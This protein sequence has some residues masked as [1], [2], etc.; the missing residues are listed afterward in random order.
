MRTFWEIF[1]LFLGI[2]LNPPPCENS[3]VQNLL[4]FTN[5]S[6][7]AGKISSGAVALKCQGVDLKNLN[8]WSLTTVKIYP[9]LHGNAKLNSYIFSRGRVVSCHSYGSQ[10]TKTKEHVKTFEDCT[11][12]RFAVPS[13]SFSFLWDDM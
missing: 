13:I 4:L 6:I 2:F 5:H 7:M 1:L 11:D 3:A 12:S 8:S 10:N 9:S